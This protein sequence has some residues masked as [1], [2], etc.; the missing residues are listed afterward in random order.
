MREVVIPGEFLGKGINCGKWTY[1]DKENIYS[2]VFGIKVMRE[3]TVSVT[4]LYGKYLPEKNDIVIGN[5][6]DATPSLWVVDINSPYIGLLL[7]E[8]SPWNVKYGETSYYLKKNDTIITK[9]LTINE[10]K[11][12]F[13]T[14][15]ERG[16]KKIMEGTII[17][18]EPAKIPRLVGK[19]G[20]MITLIKRYVKCSIAI[21][22]NGLVWVCGES[23][24]IDIVN[25][26]IELIEKESHIYGLT[27]KI[28]KMLKDTYGDK[29]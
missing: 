2:S 26:I 4:P 3:N 8:E 29:L 14:M 22:K 24:D 7:I 17:E 18:I 20:S 9:V 23:N 12:T 10:N 6:I 5:V 13:L 27:E 15:K 11:K 25:K 16:L 19:S 1:R 21:G 28:T